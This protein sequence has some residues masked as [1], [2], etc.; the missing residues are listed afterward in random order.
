MNDFGK[1]LPLEDYLPSIILCESKN[2]YITIP[3]SDVDF[4]FKDTHAH[5]GYEFMIPFID[6]PYLE[7]DGKTLLVRR[8]HILPINPEQEHGV[9]NSMKNV[10]F[11]DILIDNDFMNEISNDVFHKGGINFDMGSFQV[12]NQLQSMINT[13]IE[14][15]KFNDPGKSIQL[16]SISC[17]IAVLLLREI[18]SNLYGR[19][20]RAFSPD[21]RRIRISIEY[22]SEYFNTDFSL[23]KLA[24]IA[25]MSKYHFIRVFKNTTGKTPYEYVLDIRI[26]KAKCLLAIKDMSILDVCLECGFNNL[27]HFTTLFKKKVGVTPSLFRSM[28]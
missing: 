17:V 15:A 3:K 18:N 5:T 26:D 7:L 12:S 2:M 23:D 8:N 20:M 21:S 22:I 27:S 13:F 25:D 19:E 6:M 28:I 9:S 14:E 4:A 11:V 24:E 1:P 16:Q 10:R